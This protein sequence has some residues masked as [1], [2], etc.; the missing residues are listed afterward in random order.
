MPPVKW[1]D[2]RSGLRETQ[3][4]D[5][6]NRHARRGTAA[7]G[8]ATDDDPALRCGRRST[9]RC[10]SFS[11]SHFIEET[12]RHNGHLDVVRELVDGRTGT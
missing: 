2:A 11:P 10:P 5:S 9:S 1:V 8:E 4:D 7:L 6:T 12:S 3:R